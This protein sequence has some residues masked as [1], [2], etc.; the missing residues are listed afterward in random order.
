MAFTTEVDQLAKELSWLRQ[1]FDGI[2]GVVNGWTGG[3][4]TDP[5]FQY[6]RAR[7]GFFDRPI[8]ESFQVRRDTTQVIPDNTLTGIE[9]TRT[10][11]NTGLLRDSFS[12]G[13]NSSQLPITPSGG[14]DRG[15]LVVGHVEWD[16]STL[17]YRNVRLNFVTVNNTSGAV[18][19]DQGAQP[20]EPFNSKTFSFPLAEAQSSGIDFLT[21]PI[22]H[23]VGTTLAILQARVTVLR[24]F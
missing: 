19:F 21:I 10:R 16:G 22:Q 23:A 24:I 15:F 13:V 3:A 17:S 8:M 6:L 5:Y 9:W 1:E 7:N 20:S 14:G 11:W 18:S 2:K 12:T 4:G